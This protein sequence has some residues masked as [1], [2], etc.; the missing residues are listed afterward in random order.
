MASFN[1]VVGTYKRKMCVII[2]R[3]VAFG[4]IPGGYFYTAS[5]KEK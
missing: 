5:A 4:T 1:P 3:R 2:V